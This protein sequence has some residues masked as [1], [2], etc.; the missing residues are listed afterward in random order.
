M[1]GALVIVALLALL[2]LYVLAFERGIRGSSTNIMRGSV[3]RSILG[4][5]RHSWRWWVW[6]AACR[7]GFWLGLD[8]LDRPI[9]G[10]WIA[11]RR[12]RMPARIFPEHMRAARALRLD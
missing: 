11:G 10:I 6:T 9:Q 7:P 4:R 5:E 8:L 3:V 1:T 12:Y 2:A